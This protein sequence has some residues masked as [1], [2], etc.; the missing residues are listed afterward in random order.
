[1]GRSLHI[2]QRAR[3]AVRFW[4]GLAV[5]VLVIAAFVGGANY[6]MIRTSTMVTYRD[7]ATV[8]ARDVGWVLGTAPVLRNGRE[9]LHFTTRIDAAARLY[10]SGKI[11]H[12]LLSGDN[13][14][15]GYD[16]PTEMKA[17]LMTRGVPDSAITLDYAGFRT[18]DSDG[19]RAGDF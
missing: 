4:K 5:A 6:W 13:S 14:R 3:A 12:L 18:L 16:E 17:A 19:A 7:L 9:N 11:K 8:P 2:F 15:R 1:M 10:H